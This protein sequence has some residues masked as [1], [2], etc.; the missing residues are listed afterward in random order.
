M[1]DSVL[2]TYLRRVVWFGWRGRPSQD[3]L[4]GSNLEYHFYLKKIQKWKTVSWPIQM[5]WQH[6]MLHVTFIYTS[7]TCWDLHA[8]KVSHYIINQNLIVDFLY[9]KLKNKFLKV[10]RVLIQ[11]PIGRRIR[12][13][14]LKNRVA[15]ITESQT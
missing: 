11:Y 6:N 15:T 3:K 12:H 7:V 13:K 14:H 4:I 5:R 10:I 2:R 9:Y 8:N 1:R